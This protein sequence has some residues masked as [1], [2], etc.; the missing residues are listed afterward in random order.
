MYDIILQQNQKLHKKM[1]HCN[2]IFIFQFDQQ[3]IK[4]VFITN[5]VP[6][7]ISYVLNFIWVVKSS[8]IHL[9]GL[10]NTLRN[11]L[12]KNYSKLSKVLMLPR[13][14]ITKTKSHVNVFSMSHPLQAFMNQKIFVIFCQDCIAIEG[15][16]GS[17]GLV[18][19]VSLEMQGFVNLLN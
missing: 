14:D 15:G 6:H 10:F 19:R 5:N 2:F 17:L 3:D 11:S 12:V 7:K 4:T 8:I 9:L 16:W 18:A 1:I 13:R